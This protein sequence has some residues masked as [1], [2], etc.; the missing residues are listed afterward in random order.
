MG[1]YIHEFIL[2]IIRQLSPI[3]LTF[4]FIPVNKL[5]S[6]EYLSEVYDFGDRLNAKQTDQYLHLIRVSSKS[7]IINIGGIPVIM[8]TIFCFHLILIGLNWFINNIQ[9]ECTGFRNKFKRVFKVFTFG[10]YIDIFLLS[11]IALLLSSF[12]EIS[13]LDLSNNDKLISF[14]I[15][16][17]IAG[18]CSFMLILSLILWFWYRKDDSL[19]DIF[20]FQKFF[21]GVKD[22]FPKKCYPFLFQGRRMLVC[23]IS[24]FLNDLPYVE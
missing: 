7:T 4:H 9:N 8:L 17:T 1:P 12:S 2:L 14:A 3:L 15:A 16:C 20:Y 22:K 23:G 11:Y 21:S 13:R 10:I 19:K 6:Y 18:I 5:D 24:I